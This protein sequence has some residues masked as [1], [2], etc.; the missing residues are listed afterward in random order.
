MLF[1]WV[2]FWVD[3]K[4]LQRIEQL[5]SIQKSTPNYNWDEEGDCVVG[6]KELQEH[7]LFW[8]FLNSSETKCFI[9]S[10]HVY[11]F[12]QPQQKPRK[13]TIFLLNK[14]ATTTETK[15]RLTI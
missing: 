15:V 11:L 7:L 14:K 12:S 9:N 2:L 3:R 4:C 1:R 13:N 10:E 6:D 8:V 5:S